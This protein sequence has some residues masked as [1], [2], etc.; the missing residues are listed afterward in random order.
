MDREIEFNI[1]LCTLS[2]IE[3]VQAEHLHEIWCIWIVVV[4]HVLIK[5]WDDVSKLDAIHVAVVG[6]IDGDILQN[7]H[8]K[9]IFTAD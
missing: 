1:L 8:V 9:L 5:F 6:N 7:V 2:K 4:S 3:S